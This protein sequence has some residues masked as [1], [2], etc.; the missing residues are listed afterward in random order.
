MSFQWSL[1]MSEES[2]GGTTSPWSSRSLS[3]SHSIGND[4]C[5]IAGCS[6]FTNCSPGW[7]TSGL[8]GSFGSRG[9]IPIVPPV[10]RTHTLDT[11]A[12]LLTHVRP[13]RDSPQSVAVYPLSSRARV[14][15]RPDHGVSG[16]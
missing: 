14:F 16:N 3:S 7:G 6:Q 9:A 5:L 10:Y 4:S 1:L 11:Y 8:V 12:L 15:L 2:K 13:S